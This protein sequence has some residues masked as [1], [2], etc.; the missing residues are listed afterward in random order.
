MQVNQETFDSDISN[1][2]SPKNVYTETLKKIK[3]YVERTLN[4]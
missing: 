2:L 4:I 3:K 1:T